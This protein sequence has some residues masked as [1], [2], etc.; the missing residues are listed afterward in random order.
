MSGS[1]AKEPFTRRAIAGLLPPPQTR[2]HSILG[3]SVVALNS[4]SHREKVADTRAAGIVV[5]IHRTRITATTARLPYRRT[6][7]TNQRLYLA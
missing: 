1:R 6:T 5:L 4:Y 7:G 3:A 2:S